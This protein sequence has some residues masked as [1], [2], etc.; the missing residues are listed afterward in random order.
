MSTT[1]QVNQIQ[2][3]LSAART[4]EQQALAVY[5]KALAQYHFAIAD[6]LDWKGIRVEGLPDS[7][8][9]VARRAGEGRPRRICPSRRSELRRRRNRPRRCPAPRPRGRNLFLARSDVSFDRRPAGFLLPLILWTAASVLITFLML[10]KIDFEKMTRAQIEKCGRTMSEEQIQSTAAMQ[11][12]I[13]S[14]FAVVIGFVAPALVSLLV[15]LVFWGAFKAF[16]WDYSFSQ[17][18]GATTHAYLPERSRVPSGPADPRPPG[19]RSIPRRSRSSEIEPLR[20]WSRR[21]SLPFL[22]SLLGSIDLFALWTALLLTIGY[23]A[24]ARISRKSAG[25]LVFGVWV[26][27]VLGKA[28]VTAVTS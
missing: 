7:E 23:A 6:N 2:R 27:Y 18:Y 20:S 15:T 12:K 24:A 22:H 26:L 13:G 10:P 4:A 9:P 1:F 8:P 28:G 3:D 16:G 14:K 17:G 11:K 5:R 19:R 21:A 25:G